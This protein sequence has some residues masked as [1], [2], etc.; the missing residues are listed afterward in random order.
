MRKNVLKYKKIQAVRQLPCYQAYNC[1]LCETTRN[2]LVTDRRNKIIQGI[3]TK[4]PDKISR[5]TD[6]TLRESNERIFG[7][8]TRF[9]QFFFK[10]HWNTKPGLSNTPKKVERN[11]K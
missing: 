4:C 9:Q 10:K 2:L 1:L 5:E 8:T 11:C 6:L 3:S 7:L